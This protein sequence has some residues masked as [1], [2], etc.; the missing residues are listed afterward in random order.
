MGKAC[1]LYSQVEKFNKEHL[2]RK[3]NLE[4]TTKDMFDRQQVAGDP[5]VRQ[6]DRQVIQYKYKRKPTTFVCISS[7]VEPMPQPRTT[8]TLPIQ[9]SHSGEREEDAIVQS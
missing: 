5:E 6:F 9:D 1:S 7:P 3:V 4:L 8:A 2:A